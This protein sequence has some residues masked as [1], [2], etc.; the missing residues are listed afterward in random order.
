MSSGSFCST[1]LA[2]PGLERIFCVGV[3]Y[4]GWVSSVF[5]VRAG[6]EVDSPVFAQGVLASMMRCGWCW[7]SWHSQ[8]RQRL[9]YQGQGLLPSCG[10]GNL[11]V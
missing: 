10:G 9:L 3:P 4:V 11:R 8:Q 6:S 5:K 7:I 1:I 2:I